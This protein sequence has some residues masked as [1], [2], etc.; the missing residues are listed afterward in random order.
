[1]RKNSLIGLLVLLAVGVA[2]W[3]AWATFA[4]SGSVVRSEHIPACGRAWRVVQ[5]AA[6]SKAY[7][8]LHTLAAVAPDDVWAAGIYGGEE[9]A[10]TLVEH[11]DGREWKLSPSPSVP[12]FSNHLYGLAAVGKV[13]VW[14][15]GAS[16]Q[17]TDLW[18]TLAMHWDGV[19]WTIVETPDVGQ[20]NSLN[21][22]ASAS[23]DDVW[24]VGEVSGG[25]RGQGTQ[26]LVM[27]WDGAGWKVVD[28]GNTRQNG[29]LNAVVAVAAEDTW[30]AGSYSDKSGTVLRPFYL[31]WD[32]VGWKE[33]ES[34]GEGEIWGMSAV[35][36]T[37]IWAVGNFGSQTLVEHWSGAKWTRIASPNPGE[38]NNALNGVAVG[39][40]EVWAVGSYNDGK[41]DRALAMKWNGKEW[42]AERA[43][44]VGDY[45]DVLSAVA[46]APGGNVWA[47][48]SSIADEL[49]NNLPLVERYH[50]PCR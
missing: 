34:D 25:S 2:G 38:G 28:T 21:A 12:G 46:V 50:D 8:E 27:H 15:V 24:A 10:L 9:F 40:S 33:V 5:P 29:T 18:R 31:H 22:V 42:T 48:G 6:A 14:A 47:V 39:G 11:W 13:D 49:G 35:S 7:N 20:I 36:A 3:L 30:A 4:G 23:K 19:E 26:A 32:G 41:A 37:D 45:S 43:P 44:S 17:G 1:M 16:H